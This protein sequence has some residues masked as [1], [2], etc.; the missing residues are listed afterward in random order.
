ME[1]LAECH[2]LSQL[3]VQSIGDGVLLLRVGGIQSIHQVSSLSGAGNGI[4]AGASFRPHHLGTRLVNPTANHLLLLLLLWINHLTLASHHLLLLHKCTHLLLLLLGLA[5]RR[6]HRISVG[7]VLMG[8]NTNT[9]L[10]PTMLLLVL[11]QVVLL[12]VN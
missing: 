8:W 6:H 12:F 11:L 1:F 10:V 2:L 5:R 9:H 7:V 3:I 4:K